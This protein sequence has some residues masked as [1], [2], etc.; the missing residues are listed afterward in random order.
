[1]ILIAT[2]NDQKRC[3]PRKTHH[4]ALAD[5]AIERASALDKSQL[6][7]QPR[8]TVRKSRQAHLVVTNSASLSNL[9]NFLRKHFRILQQR[10]SLNTLF[11][12]PLQVVYHQGSALKNILVNFKSSASVTLGCQPRGKSRCQVC[13]CTVRTNVIERAKSDFSFRINAITL[14]WQVSPTRRDATS[15]TWTT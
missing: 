5:K 14:T 2:H 9:S 15:A 6:I 4:L 1:M 3:S 10:G 8:P 11:P 7:N 13:D 12:E